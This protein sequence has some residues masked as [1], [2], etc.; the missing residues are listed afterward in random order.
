ME[1]DEQMAE[2]HR[3]RLRVNAQDH[4]VE[5]EA[6]MTLADVLRDELRLTGTH[7][8]CEH[9]VCGACTVIVDG[10]LVR[11][12]AAFAVQFD[13]RHVKTVDGL[14]GEEGLNELQ[15][16]FARNDALQCG[17]C[18]PG[19]LMLATQFLREHADPTESSVREAMASNL[20]RCTGYAGIVK[21]VAEV[22]GGRQRA[23]RDRRWNGGIARL[24]TTTTDTNPQHHRVAHRF[25]V[26]LPPD[27]TFA[28]LCDARRVVRCVPGLAPP[29]GSSAATLRLR[30]DG[31]TGV[32]EGTASSFATD[33]SRR[34]ARIMLE[35]RAAADAASAGAEV[36]VDVAPH[37]G[38]CEVAL[39]ATAFLAPTMLPASAVAATARRLVEQFALNVE[40][41]LL[42]P[43]NGPV[44]A[45]EDACLP[46]TPASPPARLLH[47]TAVA[48]AVAAVLAVLLLWRRLSRARSSPG[49]DPG[50]W[51]RGGTKLSA[52]GRPHA[53]GV[54]RRSARDR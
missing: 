6:R 7:L 34:H 48:A 54:S 53:A 19:F 4:V 22:A 25:V 33:G 36:T 41:E 27:A 49:R 38:G 46:A 26:P 24:M 35:A 23:A 39:V 9:A 3:L 42:H 31:H 32:L 44:A 11:S 15:Q 21:A 28:W 20:C 1:A 43:D 47:P 5:V 52:V 50:S 10:R 18:T 14:A 12:C 17:F 51:V 40:H 37:P 8:G 30:H 16:A 45:H 2:M 29:D 13:G